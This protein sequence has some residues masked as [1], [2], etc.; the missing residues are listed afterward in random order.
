MNL[1]LKHIII[2]FIFNFAYTKT[3]NDIIS[4]NNEKEISFSDSIINLEAI[5]NFLNHI[6]DYPED[7]NNTYL[8]E[9]TYNLI[10]IVLEYLN[11]TALDELLRDIL[12]NDTNP[13]I[14]NLIYVLKI[15][16][17]NI[18][19]L[20]YI[21]NIF[22]SF[23][24][25]GDIDIND[26]LY[27]LQ[28]FTSYPGV[29]ELFFYFRSKCDILI[30]AFEF[31]IRKSRFKNLFE[32][33]K[34]FLM[35]HRFDL[36]DLGYE[37]IKVYNDTDKLAETG[38]NFFHDLN[39]SFYSDLKDKINSTGDNFFIEVSKLYNFTDPITE[40]IKN[41]FFKNPLM[42]NIIIILLD[43]LDFHKILF[44]LVKN[45]KNST[46]AF[47][48]IPNA[49]KIIIDNMKNDKSGNFDFDEVKVSIFKVVS[50]SISYE[51]LVILLTNDYMNIIHKYFL[52]EE[53]EFKKM[54]EDCRYLVKTIYFSNIVNITYFYLKKILVDSTKNKNDFITY[55]NCMDYIDFP[56][57]KKLNF[58]VT[59]VFIVA[60]L[61]DLYNKNKFNNSILKEKYNYLEGFCLPYGSYMEENETKIMCSDSDYEMIIKIILSLSRDINTTNIN[62]IGV[63]ENN[64][65]STQQA[66]SILSI[67]FILIPIIIK[68]FLMIYEAIKN[69][70]VKKNSLHKFNPSNWYKYLSVYFDI[71]N[72]INELFNFNVNESNF[73][74]LNGLIYIKG[75]LGISMIFYILGQIYLILFN[76][77]MRIINQTSFF[78]SMINPIYGIISSSLRYSPRII[79]SC[80]GYILTYKFLCFI[81]QNPSYYFLKFIFLQSYKFLHL[82]IILIFMKYSL[83]D[84]DVTLNQIT[85]PFMELYKHNLHEDK[86]FFMKLF[87]F[88]LFNTSTHEFLKGHNLVQFYY[89]PINE[90]FLFIFGTVLIS[91]GYK[92]K[93]RIDFIIII[94]TFFIYLSKLFFFIIYHESKDY[95]ST[96][97]YYLY[98]YGEIMINPIF[99]LPYYLIGMYFGLIN[100][101]IQK[102]ISLYRYNTK[103]SYAMVELFEKNEESFE[104]NEESFNLKKIRKSNASNKSDN[105][106]ELDDKIKEMPFLL[107]PVKYLNYHRMH[108][109]KYFLRIFTF[110]FFIFILISIF[111]KQIILYHYYTK[112]DHEIIDLL[113]FKDII[114]NKALNIF[115]VIDIEAIVLIINWILFATYSKSRRIIEILEFLNSQYWS[116]FVKSY[117]SFIIISTSFIIFIFYQ[118]ETVIIFCIGNIFLFFFLN[119]IFILLGV[120]YFYSCWEFPLKKIFKSFLIG[121]EI[122]NLKNEDNINLSENSSEIDKEEMNYIQY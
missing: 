97:Y 63:H 101:S 118:S 103:K 7:L 77:P 80:S 108:H 24:N 72:N 102:G 4:S 18:S 48:Y 73:N 121:Q 31:F 117:F 47:N 115:Y 56:E 111:I 3:N 58:T 23:S 28:N 37:L 114:S 65:S 57:Y 116:F 99:N 43:Y 54:N 38:Y 90:I 5:I 98:D 71:R 33:F 35:A 52:K 45:Y 53:F 107:T 76:I 70:N 93:L 42:N 89:L 10:K 1:L 67:I 30:K 25:T 81:E 27:N 66:N 68:I 55:E 91:I 110:I 64:Y 62:I 20:E 2:S 92:F 94:C 61:D 32:M 41:S 36:F 88:L 50:Q 75:L 96:L 39:N 109:K 105:N 106:G 17:D 46:Y 104:K 49:L 59:P 15:R 9:G 13:F 21:I 22:E 79:L 34:S 85:R 113:P 29:D 112:N 11:M 14:H 78:Y 74:N 84:V 51:D 44:N 83:Y 26:L 8:S 86:F 120:I 95:F 82:F 119:I 12:L 40:K 69:M 16:K 60:I 6:K 122:I 100:F 19:A 87:S